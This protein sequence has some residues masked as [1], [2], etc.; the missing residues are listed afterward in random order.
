MIFGSLSYNEVFCLACSHGLLGPITR[1]TSTSN[2]KTPPCHHIHTPAAILTPS[3]H[4]AQLDFEVM[5]P[6]WAKGKATK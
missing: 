4:P 2:A 1:T 6:D 5:D 3:A